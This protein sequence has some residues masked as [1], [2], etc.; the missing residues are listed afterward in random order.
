MN[1][2]HRIA[3][4][5]VKNLILAC[6]ALTLLGCA[7]PTPTLT[8][9][10]V[11]PT[12]TP[13]LTPRPVPLPPTPTPTPTITPTPAPP[14]PI[15]TPTPTPTP[16]IEVRDGWGY[17]VV[18]SAG[19]YSLGDTYKTWNGDYEIEKILLFVDTN[20][21]NFKGQ[22]MIADR[23]CP[24]TYSFDGGW[25]GWKTWNE[26]TVTDGPG[27]GWQRLPHSGAVYCLR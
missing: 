13:T 22:D 17:R 11:P 4:M 25:Y 24:P 16:F 15:P 21:G 10:P 1:R 3:G 7:A 5:L 6:I 2:L 23:G 18:E 19:G 20:S 26:R 9:T 27:A 12:P 14:T 8:P